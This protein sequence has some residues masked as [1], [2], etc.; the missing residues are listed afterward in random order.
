MESK[1]R[2]T[3]LGQPWLLVRLFMVSSPLCLLSVIDKALA[4]LRSLLMTKLTSLL[5]T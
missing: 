5:E 1:L 3:S 2:T 4:F